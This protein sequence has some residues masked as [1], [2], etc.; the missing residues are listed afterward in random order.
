[1]H[2]HEGLWCKIADTSNYAAIWVCLKY[3]Y[4]V[5]RERSEGLLES[6]VAHSHYDLLQYCH[7]DLLMRANTSTCWL[8]ILRIVD[9]IF[10]LTLFIS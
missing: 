3:I 7:C 6:H 9:N 1:M 2:L 5:L 4:S 8:D 10:Q